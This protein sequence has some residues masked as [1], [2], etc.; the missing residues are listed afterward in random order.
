M[1][2]TG[3]AGGE[4]FDFDNHGLR[5]SERYQ[6]IRPLYEEFAHKLK[7]ILLEALRAAEIKVSSVDA[8]GKEID[9]FRKKAAEPSLEDPNKPKYPDPLVDITDLAGIRIITFFPRTHEKVESA[10]RTELEVIERSDKTEVLV[11]EGRFGYASVHYLVKLKE[12]RLSLP[13][14]SRFKGLIGELQVRTI[15][16]HAWAE[17]EHDIQYKAADTIPETIHQRFSALA[18]MLEIADREFQAVQDE[19]EKLRKQARKSVKEG[20]LGE[21]DVTPDALKAYLDKRIGP[22][23]RMTDFSY[24]FTASMLREMGF[25][26]FGEID[27]CIHAYDDDELSRILYG[28]RQGQTSRFEYQL[29]AGMGENYIKYHPWNRSEWFAPAMKRNLEKFKEAGVKIG[30]YRPAAQIARA[31][32]EALETLTPLEERVIRMRFGIGGK[33]QYDAEQIAELLSISKE[34]VSESTEKAIAAI[35]DLNNDTIKTLL[36]RLPKKE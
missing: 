20:K 10:I 5:A 22:D 11:K 9:S 32:D 29:L 27:Q 15:L 19:D 18:G 17:I 14:Y 33:E 13:E 16:Q 3:N 30:S 25:R 6:K 1:T 23:G 7:N 35:P 34:T 28:G 36:K 31:I 21:V 4:A 12:N 2:M 24:N 26:N 8:R